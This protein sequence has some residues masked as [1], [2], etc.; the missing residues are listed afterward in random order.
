MSVLVKSNLREF[1]DRVHENQKANFVNFAPAMAVIEKMDACLLTAGKQLVNT[2]PIMTSVM[3]LR[4]QYAFK[5]A[6]GFALAGQVVETFVMLRSV[7]EYAGYALVIFET[8]SL[9]EVF[10]NRHLSDAQMKEQ[11]SHF[12]ISEV[13]STI[14]RYDAKLAENFDLFYNRAIDFG[15]HPN[16][17]ATF[18]AMTM[19]DKDDGTTGITTLALSGDPKVLAHAF[20]SV[21]QVGLTVLYILQHAFKAKFELLGIRAEIDALRSQGGL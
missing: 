21:A 5:T 1:L 2:K 3:L 4:C 12:R 8:P 18:S 7:L 11:K 15:G 10:I 16:P 14:A 9:E 13:R 20:K 6:A 19:D 17:H